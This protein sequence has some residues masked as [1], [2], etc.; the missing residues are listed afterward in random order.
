MLGRPFRVR[1]N[2]EADG[3]QL[4]DDFPHTRN[5]Q[6]LVAL[7]AELLTVGEL[8]SSL[9][10]LRRLRRF[11]DG[12]TLMYISRLK[13]DGW[14]DEELVNLLTADAAAEMRANQWRCSPLARR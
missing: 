10:V 3:M 9:V 7:P 14:S 11:N 13:A 5:E 8:R 12:L 6:Y 1:S 4:P 2:T